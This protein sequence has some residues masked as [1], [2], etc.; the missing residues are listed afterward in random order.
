MILM[1]GLGVVDTSFSGIFTTTTIDGPTRT[2]SSQRVYIR[3]YHYSN[4]F[5]SFLHLRLAI[6]ER[7]SF[8]VLHDAL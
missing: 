7:T 1:R 8:H 6:Y 4:S 5:D 2:E 3:L